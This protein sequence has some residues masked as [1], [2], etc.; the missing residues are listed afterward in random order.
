MDSSSR[1][2]ATLRHE[3][4]D[5]VP[6]DLGCTSLTGMSALC[7]HRLKEVLGFTGTGPLT[8]N[9]MDERILEWAGADFRSVGGIVSLPGTLAREGSPSERIDEWGI[10]R[11]FTGAYWDI[12]D[13][14]LADATVED[15]YAFPWPEPR[16]D[17]ALL[18]SWRE[19]AKRLH[20]EGKYVVIGEHP[21][22]GILELGC[23]MCGYDNF[24]MRLV[25]DTDFVRAFF[26]LY[27]DI[28]MNVVEQYYAALGPYIDLT[29]S[30][31]DF[32]MQDGPLMRP[33]TFRELIAP[34]FA[35]RIQG[36]KAL[37]HCLFWHHSCGSVAALLDDLIAC[38]VDILNPIQ[39][40]A[41]EMEPSHLKARFGDRIVFWG[42]VDVQAFLPRAT[43][44][45]VVQTVL[46]LV[47][48]LGDHG[49]Y[50]MAPAHNMQED[51]P[52]ENIVAWIETIKG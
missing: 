23:W 41:A 25:G 26:D 47:D 42:A 7:Q 20:T 2:E 29:M 28:Q 38:G 45:E 5:R 13:P 16:I 51:I 36:T 17:D 19:E 50:V 32:G 31:D 22:F 21:V 10:K 6:V 46:D 15:L 37:A 30:G 3:T 34:Y 11:V 39:T 44:P 33:D 12:V 52:P 8:N 18:R 40:S 35:E 43:Q 27:F 9:N 24:L 48:T 14:P 4:P 49:G 1:F